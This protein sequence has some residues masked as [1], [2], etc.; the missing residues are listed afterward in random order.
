M[1]VYDEMNAF[2]SGTPPTGFSYEVCEAQTRRER[3]IQLTRELSPVARTKR[4]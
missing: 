3:W 2:P 1:A 4:R